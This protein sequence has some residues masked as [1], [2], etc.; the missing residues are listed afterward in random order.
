MPTFDTLLAEQIGHEF[1]ASQQYIA[2]AV[3]FDDHDLPQLAGYFY[4]QAVEERNHAMMLVQ[5]RLDSGMG[6]VIPGV[7][8]VK[9]DFADVREPIALALAQEKT[10][11][12]QIQALFAAARAE[13]DGLGEQAMLWFLKEQ[14]E[15]V[16]SMQTLLN[17][18]ERTDNL[19]DIENFVARETAGAS[20]ADVSAPEAAGGAL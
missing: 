1:A 17:I 2:I 7:P 19:F 4:R 11:S 3:W 8:P 20:T 5:Y 15:E 16:A 6:V 9:N 18:A 10:V 14:V 13:N 12:S